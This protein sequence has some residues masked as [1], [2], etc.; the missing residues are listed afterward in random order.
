MRSERCTYGVI[1]IFFGLSYLGRFYVD[2]FDFCNGS[3]SFTVEMSFLVVWLLEGASLGI[4]MAFHFVNFKSG[5]LLSDSSCDPTFVLIKQEEFYRFTTEEVESG[6]IA[7]SNRYST[8][9]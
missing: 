8:T 3:T 4:L 1:S 5:T 2:L 7:T 9:G 6:S